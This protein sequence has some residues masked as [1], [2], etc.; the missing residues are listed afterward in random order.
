MSAGVHQVDLTPKIFAFGL[1]GERQA[2]RLLD[3]QCVHVGAQSHHRPRLAAFED[4]DDTGTCDTGFDVKP[5]FG[6]VLGNE[7]RR[8]CFLL[9]KFR[10][11][12]DVAPPSNQLAFDLRSALADLLFEV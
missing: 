2:F 9:P 7:S 5:Q 1:G 10:V 6:E 12:M 4:R 3:R 8:P 11:L